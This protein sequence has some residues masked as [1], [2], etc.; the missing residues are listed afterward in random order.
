MVGVVLFASLMLPVIQDA[1][2]PTKTVENAALGLYKTSN[3]V[4]EFQENY[5]MTY[6]NGVYTFE[7]ASGSYNLTFD[8]DFPVAFGSLFCATGAGMWGFVGDNSEWAQLTSI[9]Y[10]HK[11]DED[12]YS[13]TLANGSQSSLDSGN[14]SYVYDPLQVSGDWASR[15]Y[16]G[17]P[18]YSIEHKYDIIGNEFKFFSMT[19][20]VHGAGSFQGNT[21]I[22]VYDNLITENPSQTHTW[23]KLGTV[24]N[25]SVDYLIGETIG[26]Y[27]I[28]SVTV[29]LP[30]STTVD[31][32]PFLNYVISMS[33]EKITFTYESEHSDLYNFIPYLVI[34]AIILAV[35]RIATKQLNHRGGTL[36]LH[37][38][39]LWKLL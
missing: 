14:F 8:Q 39:I 21:K 38:G 37:R 25:A 22:E 10:I 32:S 9:S 6:D 24:V 13:V 34:L 2:T 35:V 28:D 23:T 11:E 3:N 19:N 31:I 15:W 29:T 17:Y 16:V 36:P 30:D 20:E 27:T 5:T 1:A 12:T 7:L 33:P 4:G 18:Y 26:V